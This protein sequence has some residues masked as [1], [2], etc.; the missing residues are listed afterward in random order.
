MRL[1]IF[2]NSKPVPGV[3]RTP[4][5][6]NV[7]CRGVRIENNRGLSRSNVEKVVTRAGHGY[8]TMDRSRR[9]TSLVPCVVACVDRSKHVRKAAATAPRQISSTGLN[10][11]A[12]VVSTRPRGTLCRSLNRGEMKMKTREQPPL[13]GSCS[14]SRCSTDTSQGTKRKEARGREISQFQ[15]TIVIGI[16]FVVQSPRRRRSRIVNQLK[17]LTTGDNGTTRSTDDRSLE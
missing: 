16:V 10:R 8:F 15:R 17:G 5:P 4:V 13:R 7:P 12:T 3:S 11:A 6:F 9:A 14:S 1:D 2:K